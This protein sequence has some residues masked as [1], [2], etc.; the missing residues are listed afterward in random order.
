MALIKYSDITKTTANSYID[1]TDALAFIADMPT[2]TDITAFIASTEKDQLLMRATRRVDM[3][4]YLGDVSDDTQLLK[5]P[6]TSLFNANGALLPSDAI[7]LEVEKATIEIALFMLENDIN[8]TNENLNYD[9]ATVGS[10]S[11]KF[12]STQVANP[13]NLML[14]P[15]IKGYL[16]PFFKSTR[17]SLGKN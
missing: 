16:K 9:S 3:F 14:T 1:E 6:R 12:K 8:A 10:V 11:V 7:P 15:Y 13:L 4:M 17:K 5:F 2:T